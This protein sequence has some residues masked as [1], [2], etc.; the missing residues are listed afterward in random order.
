MTRPVKNDLMDDCN[1]EILFSLHRTEDLETFRDYCISL[2]QNHTVSSNLKKSELINGLKACTTKDKLV[3]K[4][5]N[6]FM[7][8]KG[9]G[10]YN[11]R[12]AA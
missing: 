9:L 8:G 1:F 11:P 12:K 6:I 3:T 7:A 5:T 4:T 2:V 10:V